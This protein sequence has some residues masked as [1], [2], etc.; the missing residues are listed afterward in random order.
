MSG[1]KAF[2]QG[3]N[4]GSLGDVAAG[5][6][7]ALD[8]ASKRETS[9]LRR[10]A[11]G[12]VKV[13]RKII[14]M[15]ME[16]L[17]EAE[18]VRVTNEQFVTVRRDDLAGNLDLR[19]TVST[20]EEDNAKAEE[21]AFMLQTMGNNMDPKMARLILRDIAR[22][23]KMPE[24]AKEIE[25]YEPEPDPIAEQLRQL[26]LLEKQAQIAKIHAD[27][28]NSETGAILNQAKAIT[29]QAK[30]RSLGSKAD[31]DDLDFVEQESGVKQERDKELQSEQ[32]RG[33][34]N[35]ELLKHDLEKEDEAQKELSKYLA[36]SSEK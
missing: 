32:A 25:E 23:R 36:K 27:A 17:D 31:R 15:N 4:S 16:F 13:G 24:L 8:A 14:A 18:V 29:E 6:R 12:M 22:L 11:S 3:I 20:A 9:I 33:N 7:G 28:G 35:L 19:L 10:L 1:V 5:I 30:A 26:E 2:S 34:M 21:L